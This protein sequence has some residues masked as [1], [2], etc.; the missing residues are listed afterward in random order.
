VMADGTKNRPLYV[1]TPTE[2]VTHEAFITKDEVVFNILGHQSRLRTKPSGIAVIN[3][4]TDQMKIYGQV[5]DS[6]AGGRGTGGH[7]HSNGSPDGRWLAGDTFA[8]NLWLI[9]RKTGTQTLLTTDHKMQPDHAHPTFSDD[10]TRILFQSGHL[11]E[12]RSLDL[13]IVR[14]AR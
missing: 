3:L 13:M 7:W 9:D 11:S 1:E 14:V 12:G 2:W 4:R 10:S 5:E 8:G 6:P